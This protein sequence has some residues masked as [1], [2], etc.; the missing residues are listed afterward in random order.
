VLAVVP[1]R[2]SWLTAIGAATLH[3]YL[4]H[5]F[6]VRGAS[7]FHVLDHVAGTVGLIVLVVVTTGACLVLGSPLVR[8]LAQPFVEPKLTWLMHS[9]E[10]HWS[11]SITTSSETGDD[12]QANTKPDSISS[13]SKA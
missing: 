10:P 11:K 13:G 5:G 2:R 4:L 3:I 12:W 7:S 6:L 1:T 8:M 9:A